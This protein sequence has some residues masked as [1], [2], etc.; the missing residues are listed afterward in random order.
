MKGQSH[1]G[2]A[3]PS[4]LDELT[5]LVL[6]VDTIDVPLSVKASHFHFQLLKVLQASKILNTLTGNDF[7]NKSCCTKLP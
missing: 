7:Y 3:G 6:S 1:W 2:R 5:F 4:R